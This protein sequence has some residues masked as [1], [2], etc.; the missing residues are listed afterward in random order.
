MK[1]ISVFL[2]ASEKEQQNVDI[3]RFTFPNCVSVELNENK[4]LSFDTRRMTKS[5]LV[6]TIGDW[7]LQKNCA[8]LVEIARILDIPVIHETSFDKYVSEK[9]N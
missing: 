8:K 2:I 5:D 7:H 3:S 9:Y 6:V 4:I 1:S